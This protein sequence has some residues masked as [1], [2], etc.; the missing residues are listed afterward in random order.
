M[1]MAGD[2]ETLGYSLITTT[3][4]AMVY[5]YLHF[6]VNDKLALFGAHNY[7]RFINGVVQLLRKHNYT[8]INI[9]RI[10][11]DVF[12]LHSIFLKRID[13]GIYHKIS[14]KIEVGFSLEPA[15]YGLQGN[16]NDELS[17]F[18]KHITEFG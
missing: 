14:P 5:H 17:S 11:N 13:Y 3:R 8:E 2:E 12:A 4:K 18:R 10:L 15:T 1:Y 7:E 16:P 6:Y 9:Q